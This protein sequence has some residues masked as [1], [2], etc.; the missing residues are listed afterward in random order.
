MSL[1]QHTVHTTHSRYSLQRLSMNQNQTSNLNTNQTPT[2]N[3][4]STP[5]RLKIKLTLTHSSVTHNQP[6]HAYIH[7]ITHHKTAIRSHRLNDRAHANILTPYLSRSPSP[8]TSLPHLTPHLEPSPLTPHHSPPSPRSRTCC[9]DERPSV[10]P[11]HAGLVHACQQ[12][13]VRLICLQWRVRL[14]R[15]GDGVCATVCARARACLSVCSCVCTCRYV[16]V[17][18]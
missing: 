4:T 5:V 7:S 6:S 9:S 10:P 17:Y 16:W 14:D 18:V 3:Q 2:S 11:H 1:H 8:S 12:D 13:S 15:V